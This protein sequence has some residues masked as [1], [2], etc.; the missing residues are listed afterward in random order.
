[1]TNKISFF[2]T[3]VLPVIIW[4][5]V[6]FLLSSFKGSAYPKQPEIFSWT[7]HLTEYFVLGYLVA[8]SF[9][10]KGAVG[11]IFALVFCLLYAGSDEWH[12]TFVAGRQASFSDWGVDGVGSV[13]GILGYYLGLKS[14]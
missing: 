12:Q 4:L 14:S 5:A 13:V 10:K 3:K 6:I 1:M 2:L 8:R 11:F 7:A 9:G